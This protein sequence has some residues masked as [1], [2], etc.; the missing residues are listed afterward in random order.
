MMTIHCFLFRHFLMPL[1]MAIL[2]KL[3]TL[4]FL[5]WGAVVMMFAV[6]FLATWIRASL[7]LMGCVARSSRIL[8][9]LGEMFFLSLCLRRVEL[10]C[11]RIERKPTFCAVCFAG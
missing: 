10:M 1:V 4:W 7:Y 5:V 9:L 8:L 3:S 11:G 6:S 2:W